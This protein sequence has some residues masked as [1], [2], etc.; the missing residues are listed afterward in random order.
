MGD[1]RGDRMVET[2]RMG[3]VVT[4]LNWTSASAGSDPGG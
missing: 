2:G 4:E 1:G 3:V